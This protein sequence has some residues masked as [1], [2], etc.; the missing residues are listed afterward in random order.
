MDFIDEF[1]L[2]IISLL[3]SSSVNNKCLASTNSLPD[4]PIPNYENKMSGVSV[5]V[6]VPMGVSVGV[7]M[8][9]S[10]GVPMGMSVGVVATV[11]CG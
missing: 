1:F 2:I 6:S 7:P 4:G 3:S 5:G 10:V 9:V 11:T 8:G